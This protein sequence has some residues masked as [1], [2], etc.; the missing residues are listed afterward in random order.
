[1]KEYVLSFATDREGQLFVHADAQGLDVL[2]ARLTRLRA[3]IEKNNCEHEHL[4]TD[5]WLGDGDLSSKTLDEGVK[6]I[7]HVKIY[8]WTSEWVERHDLRE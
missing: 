5:E 4:F 6:V 1:M 8:G 3:E 7:H 2:I